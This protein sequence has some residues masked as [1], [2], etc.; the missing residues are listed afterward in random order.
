MNSLLWKEKLQ[1]QETSCLSFPSLNA[2]GWPGT[3]TSCCNLPRHRHLLDGPGSARGRNLPIN[4]GDAR[5]SCLGPVTVFLCQRRLLQ[6]PATLFRGWPPP[7]PSWHSGPCPVMGT[8][9]MAQDSPALG[10]HLGFHTCDPETQPTLVPTHTPTVTHCSHSSQGTHIPIRTSFHMY[11]HAHTCTLNLTQSHTYI[12]THPRTHKHTHSLSP[13][14]VAMSTLTHCSTP[15]LTHAHVYLPSPVHLCPCTLTRT[16]TYI[17]SPLLTHTSLSP[18]LPPWPVQR[19]LPEGG[20]G[21]S[22]CKQLPGDPGPPFLGILSSF[23]PGAPRLPFSRFDSLC[24][25]AYQ[26][27]SFRVTAPV[28]RCTNLP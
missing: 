9:V 13:T 2:G 16:D 10:G 19:A 23:M 17:P 26:L 5:S 4:L 22:H 24:W 3:L 11:S 15:T 25:E 21:E 14:Y 20:R 7:G 6:R 12:P 28:S 1:G 27:R 18:T 8:S